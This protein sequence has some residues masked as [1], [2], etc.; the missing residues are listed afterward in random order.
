ML[1]P[2][3]VITYAAVERREV[4]PYAMSEATKMIKRK[5]RNIHAGPNTAHAIAVKSRSMIVAKTMR[6]HFTHTWGH[7]F[8]LDNDTAVSV[9]A[10]STNARNTAIAMAAS[11]SNKNAEK[12]NIKHT[13]GDVITAI[14]G[15]LR[16]RNM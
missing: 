9:A 14:P 8:G 7:R 4:K 3:V 1:E 15:L 12:T 11:S 13:I 2:I 10:K 16:P 6:N 5:K